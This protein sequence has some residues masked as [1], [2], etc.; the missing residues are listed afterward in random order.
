MELDLYFIAQKVTNSPEIFKLKRV[1]QNKEFIRAFFIC[2]E[3][4]LG[5]G[6][7]LG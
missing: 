6:L 7:E 1:N 3:F 4:D 2:L 5:F